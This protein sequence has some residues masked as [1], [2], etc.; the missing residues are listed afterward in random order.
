M[1]NKESSTFFFFWLLHFISKKQAMLEH[2]PG[3]TFV[4]VHA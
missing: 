4:Y 3:Y 1:T 2:V